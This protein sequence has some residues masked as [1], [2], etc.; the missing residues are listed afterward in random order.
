MA[1][2]CDGVDT[3]GLTLGRA[4]QGR[5][6]GA[7]PS[8]KSRGVKKMDRVGRSEVEGYVPRALLLLGFVPRIRPRCSAR[9]GL[10]SA[11]FRAIC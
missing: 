3:G 7:V 1:I 4:Y 9:N 6:A 11:G 2:A 5:K 10:I 8:R